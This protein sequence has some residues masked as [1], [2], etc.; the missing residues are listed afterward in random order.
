[1]R[2]F[3]LE[4]FDTAPSV[5]ET[6]DPRPGDGELM[7]RV[8]ASSAN[9]VDAFIAGGVLRE[10]A[11][12][13]FPVTLGRDFAGTVED[14]GA[15]VDR[16]RVGDEVFGYVPHLNP[17]VHAGSWSELIT[18]PQDDFVSAAPG[19]VEARLA[20]AA[21]LAAITA[22]AIVDALAPS[23]GET[24]QVVGASGGVG[25]FVVQLVAG[26]GARVVAAGL[27]EDESYLRT[28]GAGEVVD[29]SGDV[30]A[31]VREACPDGVD[32]LADLVSTQPDVST[33]KDAGRVAS[34]RG[35]AG[36][37][38]GR[39]NVMA[40]PTPANIERVARLL[41]AGALRVLLQNTYGLE[42]AAEALQA[43]QNTHTQGKV[44]ITIG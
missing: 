33:L 42:R 25:S 35:A 29:R 27:P 36:E 12:H 21:P 39:F 44:G 30:T 9:P 10:R 13:E 14:V 17:N 11:E 19:S 15:G 8:C 37:G 26:A 22:L 20:G 40:A 38:P 32:A 4:S 34:P 18:V 43:L 3:T 1:M 23:R 31:A 6:P 16:Y 24:V 2:A 28:L 7:V 41:D 5:T